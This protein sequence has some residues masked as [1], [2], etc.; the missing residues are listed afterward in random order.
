ML[1]LSTSGFRADVV[2]PCNLDRPFGIGLIG[3]PDFAPGG[4]SIPFVPI[5]LGRFSL[6]PGSSRGIFPACERYRFKVS[7]LIPP[8]EPLGVLGEV[9]SL[10]ASGT[11]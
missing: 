10:S 7:R 3:E 9:G 6:N 11:T 1:A 4:G 5:P 8:T 2:I